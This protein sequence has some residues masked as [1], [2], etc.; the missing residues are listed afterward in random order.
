MKCA[1]LLVTGALFKNMIFGNV[2]VFSLPATVS[3]MD[4]SNQPR[5]DELH[6]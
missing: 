5:A 6:V 3:E 1:A 4:T 2:V